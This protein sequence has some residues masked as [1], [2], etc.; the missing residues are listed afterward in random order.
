[1]MRWQRVAG[2]GETPAD[3]DLFVISPEG[4]IVHLDALAHALWRALDQPQTLGELVATFAAAFPG[5]DQMQLAA[6]LQAALDALYLEG[7]VELA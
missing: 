1:M 3:N 2:G 7:L 6:D 4:E 5:E